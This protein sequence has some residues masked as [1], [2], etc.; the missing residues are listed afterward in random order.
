VSP[1][2]TL[3]AAAVLSDSGA[4]RAG[5]APTPPRRYGAV[6]RLRPGQLDEYRRLHAAVWPEVLATIHRCNIRN[7]TIYHR[8]GLLFAHYDYVGVDHDADLGRMAD[9]EATQRWWAR[10]APCQQPVETAAPGEWW[11]SLDELFHAD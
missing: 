11:S 3:D 2:G 1:D 10:T 5:A 7:Y 8:D 4:P 6:I 9:D